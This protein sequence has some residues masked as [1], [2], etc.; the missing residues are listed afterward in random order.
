MK[1]LCLTIALIAFSGLSATAANASGAI[2]VPHAGVSLDQKTVREGLQV[3]TDVCM[4]CH[5][6]KYLTYRG[7]MDYDLIGL[8]RAE[9]DELR[10][11]RTLLEGLI[12]ELSPEDATLA[13][14]KV[15]PD[16]SVIARARRGGG[17]YIAAILVGY[18]DD[19]DH[20]IPEG[21]Y[22][23]YFPGHRIAMPDPLGWFG[24]DSSEEAELKEQ[25]RAVASFLVFIG[26][27]HQMER[28]S[29]GMYVMAFL[30]LLSFVLYLLKREV[31]KDVKH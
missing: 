16:L 24:H 27:P 23:S 20:R 31:W 21:S 8:S 1:R 22:N 9:V 26:D 29:I 10:G 13:Y 2:H 11:S 15:P 17:D 28:K 5:S 18:E 19:P 6:A 25:A 12:T 3:F 4:G 7:L 30:L 14:G